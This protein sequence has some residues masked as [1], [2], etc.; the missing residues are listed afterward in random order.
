MFRRAEAFETMLSI[1]DNIAKMSLNIWSDQ[2]V[3]HAGIVAH[4]TWGMSWGTAVNAIITRSSAPRALR[5]VI[6]SLSSG[7]PIKN[8]PSICQEKCSF[9]WADKTL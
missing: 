6:T 3:Y 8:G 4:K 5:S 7:P 1:L 9:R 2:T